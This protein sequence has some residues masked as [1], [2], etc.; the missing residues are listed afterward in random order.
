M[1][2]TDKQKEARSKHVGGSDIPAI[3]GIDPWRNAY[4]CWLDKTGRLMEQPETMPMKIGRLFENGL[5]MYCQEELG[6]IQRN[7]YRSAPDF[8]I[9][10]HIDAVLKNRNEPIEAKMTT[11]AH[12]TEHWGAP[13]Y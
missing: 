5:L 3:L 10:T 9:A 7:V 11:N 1:P 12:A 13:W 6:P 8:P 4:D 2:I